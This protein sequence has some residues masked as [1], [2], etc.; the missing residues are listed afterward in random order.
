MV[1]KFRYYKFVIR[2]MWQN[3]NWKDTRQKWKMMDKDWKKYQD[4]QNQ[5]FLILEYDPEDSTV[6]YLCLTPWFRLIFRDGKYFGW[7]NPRL[8]RVI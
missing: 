7:Y 5:R 4:I 2:W 6:I 3:R 8:N 1:N